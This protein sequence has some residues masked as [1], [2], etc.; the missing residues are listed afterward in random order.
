MALIA[1]TIYRIGLNNVMNCAQSGILLIGV[2][3]PLIS[4]NIKMKNRKARIACCAFDDMSEI[5]N[6]N[7][8]NA[9]R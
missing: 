7:A 2:K 5:I 4:I 8:V 1:S 6:P 9:V 3:I